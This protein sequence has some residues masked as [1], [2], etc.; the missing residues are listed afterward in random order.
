[1]SNNLSLRELFENELHER[2][3]GHAGRDWLVSIGSALEALDAALAQQETDVTKIAGW[4]ALCEEPN[5][6][7]HGHSDEEWVEAN[8]SMI[9]ARRR[10]LAQQAQPLTDEAFAEAWAASGRQYGEDA[11]EQVR[12]GWEMARDRIPQQARP[13]MPTRERIAATIA[14]CF[15]ARHGDVEE[16]AA[17]DVLALFAKETMHGPLCNCGGLACEKMNGET[18]QQAQPEPTCEKWDGDPSEGRSSICG[19]ALRCPY[20]DS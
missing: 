18:T 12:L 15:G 6:C 10:A 19:L 17:D 16:E 2:N 11:L 5:G 1:M 4:C 8:T 3:A 14:R 7:P 20:H 13:E 9:A